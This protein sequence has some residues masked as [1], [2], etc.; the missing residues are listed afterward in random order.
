MDLV[1]I[2]EIHITETQMQ[3]LVITNKIVKL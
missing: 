2:T 1:T 3:V